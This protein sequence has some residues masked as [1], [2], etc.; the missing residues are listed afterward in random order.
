MAGE[1]KTIDA[2]TAAKLVDEGALLVDVREADEFQQARIPGSVNVALSE[3]EASDIPAADGQ[4]IVFF[5]RSGNR[6]TVHAARLAARAADAGT[7]VLGGGII[8]WAEAGLP[9][10][11]D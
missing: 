5:C 6:T 2:A 3:F 11:T 8:E 4:P 10:E 1:L 9:I 7:Y